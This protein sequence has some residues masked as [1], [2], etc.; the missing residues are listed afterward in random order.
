MEILAFVA[1]S[2]AVLSLCSTMLMYSYLMSKHNALVDDHIELV[3][4]CRKVDSTMLEVGVAMG[5]ILD[6][7]GGSKSSKRSSKYVKATKKFDEIDK[8]T[9][10]QMDLFGAHDVPSASASHSK[11]KNSIAKRIKELEEQKHVIMRELLQEGIDPVI[12]ILDAQS[13][14]PKKVRMSEALDIAAE[15]NGTPKTDPTIPRKK[16]GNVISLFEE[17]GDSDDEG[18]GNPTLH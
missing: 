12:T 14:E 10:E 8:L 6:M 4:H 7:L 1:L 13:G 16:D 5:A 17:K 2:I 3:E 11:H 18:S 15:K 9:K